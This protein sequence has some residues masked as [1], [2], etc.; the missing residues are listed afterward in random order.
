MLAIIGQCQRAIGGFWGFPAGSL[1]SPRFLPYVMTKSMIT[2]GFSVRGEPDKIF[3]LEFSRTAGNGRGGATLASFVL[4]ALRRPPA[5]QHWPCAI[6]P[7][8]FAVADA[9][10]LQRLDQIV[11]R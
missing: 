1:P 2:R 5:R 9:P 3:Y 11:P 4:S 10:I 7:A 8:S 6:A